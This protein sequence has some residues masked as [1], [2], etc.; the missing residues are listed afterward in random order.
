M[1]RSKLIILTILLTCIITLTACGNKEI[2]YKSY[3][4]QFEGNDPWENKMSI[5]LRSFEDD[6]F[7]IAY[8]IGI[9][10]DKEEDIRIFYEENN[11]VKDGVINFHIKGNDNE[12]NYTFNYSGTITLKN[13]KLIVKY[14]NGSITSISSEGGASA[15]QVGALEEKDRTII[16]EKYSKE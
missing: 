9:S 12:D 7:D 10:Q 3:I 6:T 13:G 1:K 14:E 5:T 2:D 8:G 15:Y 11:K 4:G 16:L